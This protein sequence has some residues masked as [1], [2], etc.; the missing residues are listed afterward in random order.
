LVH[1]V[2]L[3]GESWRSSLAF[4]DALRSDRALRAEYLRMKEHA[5]ALAPLGRA[6]YNE[7]KDSFFR[8]AR[9]RID[10]GGA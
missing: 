8:A 5:A 3:D 2:E 7:L 1:V 4:R 10:E 9:H 6:Q